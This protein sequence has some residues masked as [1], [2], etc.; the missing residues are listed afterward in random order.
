MGL[1]IEDPPSSGA[2]YG[3]KP[4]IDACGGSGWTPAV[5]GPAGAP[6]WTRSDPELDQRDLLAHGVEHLPP[7]AVVLG[8]RVVHPV[9]LGVDEVAGD[10]EAPRAGPQA[11][12]QADP[13]VHQPLHGQGGDG[14]ERL[15]DEGEIGARAHPADDDVADHRPSVPLT[16]GD[17]LRSGGR[18]RATWSGARSAA[19]AGRRRPATRRSPSG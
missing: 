1:W 8:L 15:L 14:V 13:D 10:G 4:M 11:G 2:S 9:G 7:D 16:C 3:D 6:R 19:T 5:D 17:L 12:V 18:V